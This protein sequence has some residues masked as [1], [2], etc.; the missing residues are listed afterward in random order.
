MFKIKFLFFFYSEWN[1]IDIVGEVW[2]RG[3]KTVIVLGLNLNYL[4]TSLIHLIIIQF[5]DFVLLKF[6]L[7]VITNCI[8]W[9]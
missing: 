3:E 2:W 4:K 9:S 8:T 6:L 1:L 7:H 5:A